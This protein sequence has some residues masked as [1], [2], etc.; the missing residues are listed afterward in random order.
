MGA[1]NSLAGHQEPVTAVY[2]R[3]PEDYRL[4]FLGGGGLFFRELPTRLIGLEYEIRPVEM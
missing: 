3:P 1:A 4:P 2:D